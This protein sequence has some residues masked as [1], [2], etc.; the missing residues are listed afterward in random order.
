VKLTILLHL[1]PRSKNAW[2][3]TSTPQYA[4]M[5][6]CSVNKKHRSKFTFNL[7]TSCFQRIEPQWCTTTLFY[8]AS[9]VPQLS[10]PFHSE[11]TAAPPVMFHVE[12]RFAEKKLFFSSHFTILDLP[13]SLYVPSLSLKPQRHFLSFAPSK[14]IVCCH[15]SALTD[16]FIFE[17]IY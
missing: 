11:F 15:L 8:Y 7:F 12:F 5:A 1:V 4:L 9:V 10:V 2:N 3:Y 14:P 13:L 17:I 6:W 16:S